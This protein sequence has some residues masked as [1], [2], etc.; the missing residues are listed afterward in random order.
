M[1]HD[2]HQQPAIGR[3]I[4]SSSFTGRP[5]FY[6][7]KFQ[8]G[9]AIIGEYHKPD[10][11]ITMTCNPNWPEIQEALLPGQKPQDR[12]DVVTRVFNL[13]KKQLMDDL[14]KGGVLG[15][16]EAHMETTEWQKR[17]MP[18]EHILIILKRRGIPLTPELVDRIISAE[19]PP[20]PEDTND[21][22]IAAERQR[23]N[24]IVL[25][26]MIHGPCSA[27]K[28]LENGN[29][30]KKFPKEFNPHTIVDLLCNL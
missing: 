20:S 21:P 19:L 27:D 9:M 3:K 22:T 5:R 16:V 10:F 26:N 29:C 8:D 7:A 28:C 24:D 15:E 18:H 12:P 23:L 30:T 25:K 2:D 6:N 1:F 13:K 4:L 17:G 11:F 14:T